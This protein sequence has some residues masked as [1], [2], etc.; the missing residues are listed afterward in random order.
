MGDTLARRDS[1]EAE[2][3][4][5]ETGAPVG[6]T[7]R[8][9]KG[10]AAEAETGGVGIGRAPGAGTG[11]AAEEEDECTAEAESGAEAEAEEEAA[12]EAVAERAAGEGWEGCGYRQDS[13]LREQF[14]QLGFFSSHLTLRALQLR[15]PRRD[16]R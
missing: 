14:L 12:A 4:E 2:D 1:G 7:R 9:L 15:Q 11:A 16:L 8:G 10:E 5:G 13:F 6:T 3:A